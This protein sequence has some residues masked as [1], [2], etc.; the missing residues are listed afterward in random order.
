MA[1]RQRTRRR[2]CFF[3]ASFPR[4]L[5]LAL[6]KTSADAYDRVVLPAP[7]TPLWR[8]L[9]TALL[10]PLVIVAGIAS[11]S[12]L[13]RCRMDGVTRSACC[14]PHDVSAA[15]T[16]AFQKPSCCDGVKTV[17][18]A[19]SPAEQ[20]QTQQHVT[21]PVMFAVAVS[22]AAIARP[23]DRVVP[24]ARLHDGPRTTTGPP[25][26]IRHRALLI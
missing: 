5:A 19:A 26:F 25:L 1:E 20:R 16:L 15:N 13:L 7:T 18:D 24:R 11:S 10:L 14:C 17:V 12:D 4:I 3:H 9:A 8:R 23:R 22:T 21:H 2:P 6:A